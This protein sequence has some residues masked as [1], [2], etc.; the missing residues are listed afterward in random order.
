MSSLRAYTTKV[1][2]MR[3]VTALLLLA[4][5]ALAAAVACVRED[6]LTTDQ[7]AFALERQLMC[8]VCDGQTIDESH[9]QLAADMKAVIREQ[10]TAGKTNQEIRDY[11]VARYGE[12][13]LAAPEASGFNLL[14]WLMPAAIVG[15][16]ALVV[17]FV[18]KNMRRPPAPATGTGEGAA[19]A[20]RQLAKYLEKVDEDLGRNAAQSA[21]GGTDGGSGR[22]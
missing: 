13:V 10:I 7:R 17:F 15:G 11:F 12:S 5:L 8:V 2:Q 18:L 4:L 6:D 14:V 16:G 9:S 1:L 19:V 20:D 22:G 21:G 3:A